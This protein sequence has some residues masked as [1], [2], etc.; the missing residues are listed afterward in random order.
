M[1][2]IMWLFVQKM[3]SFFALTEALNSNRI[4]ILIKYLVIINNAKSQHLHWCFQTL[5]FM[6]ISPGFL[7]LTVVLKS[8][9]ERTVSH[10]A[11]LLHNPAEKR[12]GSMLKVLQLSAWRVC[13]RYRSSISK[14]I[15]ALLSPYSRAHQ[16]HLAVPSCLEMIKRSVSG[17][18]V[19][20]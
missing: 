4:G 2:L 11:L 12:G 9:N 5:M 14:L 20:L 19:L 15:N 8:L 3:V 13:L 17:W 16:R 7:L 1:S 18:T 10:V 6:V